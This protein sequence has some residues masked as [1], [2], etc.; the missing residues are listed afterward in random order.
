M[1]NLTNRH[2]SEIEFHDGKVDDP[3]SFGRGSRD[4]YSVEGVTLAYRALLEEA[5][6][7]DG[8]S[9]LDFGCGEGWAALDYASRGA[10]SVAAFDISFGAL[11]SAAGN[12]SRAGK[13]GVIHLARMAAESL[14]FEEGTF[15]LVLGNAILHHTDME[16]TIREIGRVLRDGGK[17]IFVEPLGH[18]P[19]IAAFRK[20]TPWRRSEYEEP[21]KIPALRRYARGF[22]V[23]KVVG[24]YLTSVMALGAF[25]VH[26]NRDLLVRTVRILHS[27]DSRILARFPGLNRYCFAAMIVLTK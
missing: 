9:V 10:T 15:D 23:A 24:F 25:M 8:K 3:A 13:P 16:M 1:D 18:N 22:R 5:G 19:I 21:I 17:A 11:A 2:K 12:V 4:F 6:E 26:G 14:A 27:L 20:L 7:L